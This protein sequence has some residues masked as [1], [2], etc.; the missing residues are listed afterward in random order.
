MPENSKIIRAVEEGLKSLRIPIAAPTKKWTKAV[1][2]E[3]CRIG[4][5]SFGCKVYAE[6]M[7]RNKKDGGE[8]LY[9]VTW[10]EYEERGDGEL[11]DAPLVAEC[12]WGDDQDI[13]DDFEKL[14]LARAGVRVM[15]VDGGVEP[16][17]QRIADWLA[18]KVKKFKGSRAD[19]AWLLAVV[20]QSDDGWSFRYF[21]L[22]ELAFGH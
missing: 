3:L 8:G 12:E 15:I 11:T 17:S 2:T 10:L 5:D 22:R 14:L 9:D 19:D 16:D 7:P 1:T 20:K 13:A 21:Q 18:G 6:G 4:R